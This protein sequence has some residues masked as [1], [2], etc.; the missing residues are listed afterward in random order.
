MKKAITETLKGA[1]APNPVSCSNRRCSGRAAAFRC[2]LMALLALGPLGRIGHAQ[3]P[4]LI[5][6]D[7]NANFSGNVSIG[8]SAT[9]QKLTVNGNGV[10]NK[11]FIGDLDL[12]ANWV[13]IA[14]GSSPSK[15]GY[16][17]VQKSDGTSTYI[18][19]KS[20]VG[21]IGFRID[22][23]DTMVIDDSGN[24]NIVKPKATL[25]VAGDLQEGANPI[26]FTSKWSG[27]GDGADNDL[28][29]EISNDTDHFKSLMIAG[30]KSS[31]TRTVSIWD[32]LRVN[33]T[34]VVDG[35]IWTK[36]AGVWR[37][38]GANG[39]YAEGGREGEVP[40]FPS[41]VRLKKDLHPIRS[42]LESIRH[43]NG[44]TYQ[45]NNEGLKYFTK[46]IETNVSAG[47]DATAEQNQVVWQ[48]ERNKEYQK[49]SNTQVGVIAQDVEAVLPQAVSTDAAGYKS[50]AYY[51]LIPLFIEALKE[52]DKIGQEQA[53]TA[54]NQ[55]AEIQRLTVAND[56]AQKQ[57]SE[58]QGVKQK[59]EYLEATVNRL[60]ADERSRDRREMTSVGVPA[61]DQ[62]MAQ[63]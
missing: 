9:A 41:D 24:V 31:G 23:A 1:P 27:F 63:K 2:T 42:P 45:W 37:Y 26:K 25:T 21:S 39:L 8:A 51:E 46:D 43:L 13:G 62:T 44:V 56:A 49:L 20:G 29:A 14:A 30:N 32:R 34:L 6:P 11:I 50:V 40:T 17:F 53:Q 59:L 33:G 52:E 54:A 7:G 36:Q 15:Q 3:Q 35:V 48:N 4:L 22:N 19:K 61:A 10:I 55:Q 5:T 38:V 12:G 60:T 57:L 28:K 47:P 58:L 16:G 18:N